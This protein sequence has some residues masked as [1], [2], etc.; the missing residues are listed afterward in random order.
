[1]PFRMDE[2]QQQ[3]STSAPN[4]S[5]V[6]TGVDVNV[7]KGTGRPQAPQGPKQSGQYQNIQQYLQANQPQAQQM[8]SKIAGN[9]ETKA[10]E[11]TKAG[12]ALQSEP[13]KV[14]EYKPSDV[15]SKATSGQASDLEKSQYQNIK[16]TGGYTGPQDITGLKGYQDYQTK[17]SQ[18]QEAVGQASNEY[19]Q[20]QLLQNAFNRPS[21]GGGANILDQAL[22]ARSEGGKQTIADIGQKYSGLTE[23]LKGFGTKAGQNIAQAQEQ[24]GKNIAQFQ[25]AES[26]ARA[27]IID[28][29]AQKA[30]ESNAMN[31]A[32]YGRLTGDV[33]DLKLTPE[34][35]QMLGLTAGQ[36]TYGTDL[37]KYITPAQGEATIQ[38][39]ASQGDINKYNNLMSFL[40]ANPQELPTKE[41]GYQ[42]VNVNKEQL[43]KDLAAKEAEYT[44]YWNEGSRGAAQP[45]LNAQN[46]SNITYGQQF[47]NLT[48]ADLQ[49]ILNE[50]KT[51]G[52]KGIREKYGLGLSAAAFDPQTNLISNYLKGI[53][54][55]YNTG[56]IIEGV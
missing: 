53:Q 29:L 45:L 38:N 32:L 19:G 17:A 51:L 2:E 44:N 55:K 8:A 42:G 22:L 49:N 34:T 23:A 56:N 25:P 12:E 1:M 37:S 13:P 18:A 47:A 15:L 46:N 7:P 5:G 30:A 36:H 24:A 28:P 41:I 3:Q 48:A 26:Q 14:G 43:A 39:I 20:R 27:A 9:V 52:T 50:Q 21:Y 35:M 31:Q 11:A 40:G 10:Q 54:D 6:S 4:I 16:Q 33:S